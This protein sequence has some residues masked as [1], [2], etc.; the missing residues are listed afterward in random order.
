MGEYYEELP[1]E[2]GFPTASDMASWRRAFDALV[3]G[4]NTAELIGFRMA[5]TGEVMGMCRSKG[6]TDA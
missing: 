2:K 4:G 1:K 3:P 6:A 5:D